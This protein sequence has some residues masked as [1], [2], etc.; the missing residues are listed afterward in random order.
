M[1]T[2]EAIESRKS[3]RAFTSQEVDRAT[4]E[5]ILNAAKCA[6]SGVNMQPWKVSVLTGQSKESLSDKMEQAFR[7]GVKQKMD[8]AYYPKVFEGV[9]KERRKEMGLLMY[10]K[11]GITRE[12]K[13]RQIDQWA[14]NYRAFNAP[15]MLIFSIDSSLEQGSYLDY[16]MFIQTIMIAA[17]DLGLAT[18][19]QAALGEYPD[20]VRKELDLGDNEEIVCGMSL[21]FEDKDH[22]V[23]SFDTSRVELSDFVNFFE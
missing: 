2:F 15:V 4:I 19:P 20:I 23:N 14:L 7:D 1:N 22:D 13:Q 10:T 18:C 8:Y 3:V 6:P 17:A 21:G 16:G 11:L 9:Y 5:K 12:D